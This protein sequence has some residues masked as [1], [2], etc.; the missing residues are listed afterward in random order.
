MTEHLPDTNLIERQIAIKLV[1]G[2][3][4]AGYTISVNDGEEMTLVKSSDKD[5]I[6]AAMASTCHDWL[7]VHGGEVYI[8][9]VMLVWGNST[10]LIS[11]YAW[12]AP[13]GCGR[14]EALQS[15]AARLSDELAS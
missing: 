7:I 3:L 15:G 13:G 12:P 14:I 6:L 8:G 5:A 1:D 4:E 10:D 9:R 2:I 11:D